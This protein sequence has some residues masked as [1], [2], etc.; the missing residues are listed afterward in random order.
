MASGRSR[1]PYSAYRQ[2]LLGALLTCS[3]AA[4]VSNQ[5]RNV[6][7]TRE[8]SAVI[9]RIQAR[10]SVTEAQSY[11][12]GTAI[13]TSVA[14]ASAPATG[15][16]VAA[17]I[18]HIIAE[19]IVQSSDSLRT[20]Y[21][22]PLLE[23]TGKF[24]FATPFQEQFDNALA[25]SDWLIPQAVSHVDSPGMPAERKAFL[26]GLGDESALFSDTRY[27][28]SGDYRRL[29]VSTTTELWANRDSLERKH[30]VNPVHRG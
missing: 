21:H 11:S 6:Q 7:L 9:S 2:F 25:A 12:I 17:I 4:C 16:P 3:L 8:S 30:Q 15:D 28:F 5:P 20:Q 14:H 19:A 1:L 23:F 10:Q 13:D 22:D 24:D 27:H 18:G 29:Y 26:G